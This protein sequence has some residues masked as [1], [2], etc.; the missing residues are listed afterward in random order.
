MWGDCAQWSNSRISPKHGAEYQC[1]VRNIIQKVSGGVFLIR[2]INALHGTPMPVYEDTAHE[3]ETKEDQ[4]MRQ[5]RNVLKAFDVIRESEACIPEALLDVDSLHTHTCTHAHTRERA[6]LR[7]G[8]T[9][10]AVCTF[11]SSSTSTR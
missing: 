10:G 2:L 5:R 9:R 1:T 11:F 8:A 6:L 3:G 7:P 4:R